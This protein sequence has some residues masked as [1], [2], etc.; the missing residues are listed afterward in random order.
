MSRAEQGYIYL[1]RYTYARE[2]K[3]RPGIF[4]LYR[5]EWGYGENGTSNILVERD[6]LGVPMEWLGLEACKQWVEEHY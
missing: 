6:A 3:Q 4:R 1:G 2:M 5:G